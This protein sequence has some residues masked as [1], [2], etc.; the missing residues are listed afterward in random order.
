MQ[1]N[2]PGPLTPIFVILT[3]LIS[4]AHFIFPFPC[5]RL[6]QILRN[7]AWCNI[8]TSKWTKNWIPWLQDHFWLVFP[9]KCSQL[10]KTHLFI[11]QNC[12]IKRGTQC[13]ADTLNFQ[14]IILVIVLTWNCKSDEKCLWFQLTVSSWV[15]SKTA[16]CSKWSS[17]LKSF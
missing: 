4:L 1:F 3:R 12:Y 9:L 15:T 16:K 11:A 2:S 14:T 13:S 17:C 7:S 6:R 5:K 10:S 8:F